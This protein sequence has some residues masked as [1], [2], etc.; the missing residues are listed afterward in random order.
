MNYANSHIDAPFVWFIVNGELKT[1]SV[2]YKLTDDKRFVKYNN[3][4]ADNDVIEVI[5][6]SSD[7][8]VT[9]KFGFSPS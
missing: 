6:F 2:D 8:P 9:P 3:P 5:Q 1:P 7:G 4:L